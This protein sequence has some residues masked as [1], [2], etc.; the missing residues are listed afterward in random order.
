MS[1]NGITVPDSRLAKEATELVRDVADDLLF[2]HVSRVYY[3]AALRGEKDAL[4]YDPELLYV[5]AMFH[6]LGL[7][8]KYM[9][10]DQRFEIDAANV[11]YD[12]LKSHGIIDEQAQ[13]VWQAI[14]LH[15]TPE[16]PLHM[17]SEVQLVT[18]GVEMDVMGLAFDTYTQ[19]EREAV[20]E[21]HPRV[22]FKEGVIDAFYQG[23]KH[24]PQTVFGNVK[25]DVLADKD[26]NFERENFVD[27]IRSSAWPE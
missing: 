23:L 2:G 3:F 14:A 4:R 13:T 8:E 22:N 9:T 7:T 16:I 1:V 18:R 26:P 10:Q 25:S 20:T 11:A 15:T 21:L 27:K 19:E 12:F 5:G 24:R 6:D 17:A